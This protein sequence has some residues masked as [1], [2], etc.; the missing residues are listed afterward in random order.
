[1]EWILTIIGIIAAVAVCGL[2]LVGLGIGFIIFLVIAAILALV[3]LVFYFFMGTDGLLGLITPD[4]SSSKIPDEFISCLQSKT[5]VDTCRE[6]FTSWPK[7]RNELLSQL[8]TNF[9]RD[10]GAKKSSNNWNIQMEQINGKGSIK[11]ERISSYELNDRVTE[12]FVLSKDASDYKID[13]FSINY[14]KGAK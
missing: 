5:S 6:K 9:K 2:L 1:M 13:N 14:Q 8:S 4:F 11:L 12:S 10:L 7:D 3:G